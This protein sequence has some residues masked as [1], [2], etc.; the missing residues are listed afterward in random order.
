MVLMYFHGIT[1]I[2]ILHHFSHFHNKNVACIKMFT[3]SSKGQIF[4]FGCPWKAQYDY[5]SMRP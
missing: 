1:E 2:F 5:G 4:F 3:K